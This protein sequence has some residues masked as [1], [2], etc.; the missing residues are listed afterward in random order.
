[1]TG[2]EKRYHFVHLPNFFHIHLYVPNFTIRYPYDSMPLLFQ[3]SKLL[4]T[5]DIII[6]NCWTCKPLII[7]ECISARHWI[8]DNGPGIGSWCYREITDL[9]ITVFDNTVN[10]CGD[11]E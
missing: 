9:M 4:S 10:V 1:M 6:A 8:V 2:Y 7:T 5:R 3:K 11:K